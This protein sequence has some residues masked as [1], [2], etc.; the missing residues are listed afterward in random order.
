MSG[1][2]TSQPL[3]GCIGGR[4]APVQPVPVPAAVFGGA[5][6]LGLL[7]GAKIGRRRAE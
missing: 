6:L 1:V 3:L 7:G 5:G 2:I 4:R